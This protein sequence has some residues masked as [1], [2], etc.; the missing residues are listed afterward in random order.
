MTHIPPN[1]LAVLE[2]LLAARDMQNRI[3]WWVERF[4]HIRTSSMNPKSATRVRF[5][6][7]YTRATCRVIKAEDEARAVIAKA[8]GGVNDANL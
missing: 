3:A 1:L 5:E 6:V 7:W 4:P 8:R 2:E